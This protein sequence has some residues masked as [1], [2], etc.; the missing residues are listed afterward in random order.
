MARLRGFLQQPGAGLAR[1]LGRAG[2]TIIAPDGRDV[3]TAV[4]T[5]FRAALP[6]CGGDR[7]TAAVNAVRVALAGQKREGR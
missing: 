3:T 6:T 5:A 1:E 4:R 2:T 7:A